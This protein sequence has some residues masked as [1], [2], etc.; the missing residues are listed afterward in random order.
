VEALP[1]SEQG[2]QTRNQT[3][4]DQSGGQ[5]GLRLTGGAASGSPFKK[6]AHQSPPSRLAAPP[7]RTC[8]K[9]SVVAPAAF[10]VNRPPGQ[11]KSLF[12]KSQANGSK[13]DGS[14]GPMI[15]NSP[16]RKQM[17]PNWMAAGARGFQILQ[18]ASKWLQIGRQP[19]PEDSKFSKSQANGSKSGG[20]QGPDDSKFSKSQANGSKLDG[21][22]GPMVPNSPNRKQMAPNWMAA[23]TPMVPNSPNRKQMAPNSPNRKITPPNWPR[24]GIPGHL[25]SNLS[26]PRSFSGFNAARQ[27]NL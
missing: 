7:V 24:P 2:G 15:P 14:Q 11:P 5:P 17:A 20:S 22:R 18:I 8:E 4:A 1:L 19:G 3:A 21:S 12:S 16:N 9:I 26:A 25:M 27:S 6:E 10:L 13:L 23:R